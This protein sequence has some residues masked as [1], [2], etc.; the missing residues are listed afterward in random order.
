MQRLNR[1]EEEAVLL[2]FGG[3]DRAMAREIAR[4]RRELE[5]AEYE[6]SRL[7][8]QRTAGSGGSHV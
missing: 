1:S 6:L 3:R 5:A 4:L 8:A 2:E 7:R